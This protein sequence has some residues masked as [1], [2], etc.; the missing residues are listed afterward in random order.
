MQTC[1]HPKPDLLTAGVDQVIVS[2]WWAICMYATAIAEA[3]MDWAALVVVQMPGL[4]N[5]HL[6][7]SGG[8]GAIDYACKPSDCHT[9]ELAS[10]RWSCQPRQDIR[11]S[12]YGHY[13]LVRRSGSHDNREHLSYAKSFGKSNGHV[14]CGLAGRLGVWRAAP[15]QP[16]EVVASRQRWGAISAAVW[17]GIPKAAARHQ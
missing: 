4:C 1:R 7:I 2:F 15:G 14:W 8:D 9:F 10:K 11:N 17:G 13:M 3:A 12:F 5:T 16:G 6:S